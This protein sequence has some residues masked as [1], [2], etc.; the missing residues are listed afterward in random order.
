MSR[1]AFRNTSRGGSSRG[2]AASSGAVWGSP[3]S[4]AQI[5]H[6]MKS[7]FARSR[8]HG[9]PLTVVVIEVDR[10]RALV[11]LH[12][13]ELR[14][15]V[16]EAL[17]KLLVEGTRS[18]DFV[19]A[20]SDDRFLLLL[21]HT[22][23]GA[24]MSVA[25]RLRQRFS[26]LDITVRGQALSLSLSGGVTDNAD[27]ETLFFDTMLSQAEVALDWAHDARGNQVVAFSR[28]RFAAEEGLIRRKDAPPA[29]SAR[30]EA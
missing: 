12:G 18:S 21:P 7:E 30:D 16:R 19:G 6:L 15:A 23:I 27:K 10:L 1:P 24:A 17:G 20:A 14:E 8:R 28:D 2:A 13:A 5:L 25:E 3:F 29:Q 22:E 4:H 9:L 11:D 26:E